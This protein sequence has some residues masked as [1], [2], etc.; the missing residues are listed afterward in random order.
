MADPGQPQVDAAQAAVDIALG[1][2]TGADGEAAGAR[3]APGTVMQP[4][5]IEFGCVI[6]EGRV[7]SQRLYGQDGHVV[8]TTVARD[9]SV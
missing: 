4:F 2:Q 6:G 8:S 5:T 7:R 1:K 3:L 9:R